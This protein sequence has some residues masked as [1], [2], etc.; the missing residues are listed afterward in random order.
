MCASKVEELGADGEP[1]PPSVEPT[2]AKL[3][4]H[5]KW[6][7]DAYVLQP[8]KS[9]A[10][11]Q[12]EASA[13]EAVSSS[14]SSSSSSSDSSAPRVV[15]VLKKAQLM[16]AELY[17]RFHKDPQ[18]RS[19]FGY[20]DIDRLTVF[21]DNVLPAVLRATGVLKYSDSLAKSVDE[22]ERIKK[23][24]EE[25]AIRASAIVACEKIVAA[26]NAKH[27]ADG[28]IPKLTSSTLDYHLWLLGKKEEYRKL[29]RH[30]TYSGFY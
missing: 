6:L 9:E 27:E 17:L 30:S 7:Q 15:Y 23:R 11:G 24:D 2:L 3:V 1:K 13:D 20:S 26:Y 14:S 16:I 21:S 4:R 8:K 29:K 28:N 25:C 5:F 22:G 10:N 12:K 19:V 18:L